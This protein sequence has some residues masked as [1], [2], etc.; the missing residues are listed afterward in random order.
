MFETVRPV[1]LKKGS[2][3]G[4]TKGVNTNRIC[5]QR[6]RNLLFLCRLAAVAKAVEEAERLTAPGR[7]ARPAPLLKTRASPAGY[8]DTGSP[9]VTDDVLTGEKINLHAYHYAGNNPVKYVDP[10]GRLTYENIGTDDV[11]GWQWTIEKGDTITKIAQETGFTNDE[12]LA[13]NP[14]ITDADKIYAGDSINIPQNE[15]IRAFQWATQQIGS[16]DYAMESKHDNY[17]KNTWKCT[18]FI[19]DAYTKGSGINDYPG[20]KIWRGW[21]PFR[22]ATTSDFLNTNSL[23]PFSITGDAKIGDLAIFP[24]PWGYTLGHAMIK[25]LGDKFIGAGEISVNLRDSSYMN[26]SGYGKPIY[27]KY[28]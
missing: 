26:R 14:Q 7:S 25:G 22:Y 6:Y 3:R 10:D 5:V 9:A 20:K 24:P 28:K 19:G 27:W 1:C 23:G 18:A 2:S 21:G 12:I 13:A 11:P 16:E 15:R 17:G 4:Y 8:A